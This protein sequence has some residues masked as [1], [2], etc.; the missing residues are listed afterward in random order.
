MDLTAQEA[1][2]DR[3]SSKLIRC[4]RCGIESVE[5]S[6]FIIPERHSKPP[7]D[8]RCLTC[9]QRRVTPTTAGGVAAVVGTL[10]WPL[11]LLAGSQRGSSQPISLFAVLLA[12]VLVPA[13]ILTH[14]VGHAIAGVLLRLEISGMDIGYG[15]VVGRVQIGGF[16]VQLH[17]W[18]VCGCVYL[19]SRTSR[20]LRT[21]L[22]ISILAGPGTNVAMAAIATTYWPK[23]EPVT[24]PVPLGIWLII[25]ALLIFT[26]LVPYRTSQYGRLHRSDGLALLEIPRMTTAQLLPHLTAVPLMRAWHRYEIDDYAGAKTAMEQVLLRAPDDRVAQVILAASLIGL[27]QY[28][29]ARTQ[30]TPVAETLTEDPP[31]IRAMVSNALA[32]A[33][34]LENVL[35]PAKQS[36]LLRAERLSQEAYE[37]Y[38]CV[39]E[40]RST[41]A[42]VLV[43]IGSPEAALSLLGYPHYDTGTERQRG[44]REVTRA[45]AFQKLGRQDNA[46]QCTQRAMEL[47]PKNMQ[48]LRA[49]GISYS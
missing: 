42:L 14:E 21:R 35:D 23:W 8:I 22:W 24:G 47:D 1:A 20:F 3:N 43:A 44:H 12:A 48:T 9:E 6:C 7:H 33:L 40:Y 25:N 26:A 19:G 4:A 28:T 36:E 37:A 38:P 46:D 2:I 29:A 34:L 18:P 31:A 30:L 11:F 10:F 32:V 41:R 49:L 5:P 27:E 45:F 17:R 16:R 39:L 15:P 13:A